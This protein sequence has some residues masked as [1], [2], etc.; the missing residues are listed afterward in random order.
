MLQL[1]LSDKGSDVCPLGMG[2]SG[3]LSFLAR[4]DPLG[5]LRSCSSTGAC[6]EWGYSKRGKRPL[7]S[8]FRGSI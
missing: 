5:L 3:A 8:A 1:R 2:C 7:A 6:H 4:K